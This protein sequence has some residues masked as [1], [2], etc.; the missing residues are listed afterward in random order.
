ME[1]MMPKRFDT[2]NDIVVLRFYGGYSPESLPIFSQPLLTEDDHIQSLAGSEGARPADW[3]AGLLAQARMRPG[4]FIGVSVLEWRHRMLLR[5]LYD[6]RP[7]PTD[8]LAILPPATDATEPEIWE[9]GGGLPGMAR[10]AVI[11]EDP[12]QLAPLLLDMAASREES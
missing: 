9:S 6:Q 8:S 11:T 1:P 12:G 7:A 3:M 2:E 5:W 10:I 4:L